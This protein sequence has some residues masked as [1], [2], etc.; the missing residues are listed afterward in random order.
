[1]VTIFNNFNPLGINELEYITFT[2]VLE[3]NITKCIQKTLFVD[4]ILIKDVMY[5][6]H[7]SRFI[8]ELKKTFFYAGKIIAFSEK[9]MPKHEN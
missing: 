7:K 1:M 2:K 6:T 8:H 4:G 9:A 3:W 5:S